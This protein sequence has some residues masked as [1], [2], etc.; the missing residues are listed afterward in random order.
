MGGG[1][2]SKL[3]DDSGK[4][5]F[6][7]F[8]YRHYP[9]L[10]LA[11][12]LFNLEDSNLCGW[13]RFLSSALFDA[14]GYELQL[15]KVKVNGI[16]GIYE[17]CPDLRYFI[18]DGTERKLIVQKTKQN[19]KIIIQEKAKLTLLKIKFLFIPKTKESFIYQKLKQQE[20]MIKRL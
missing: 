3:G 2:K 4:L 12:V 5:F 6:I 8:Y 14:L 18:G 10:R 17:V 19:K 1:R 9:A 16:R 7:L 15:P 11:Q 13:V 20:F